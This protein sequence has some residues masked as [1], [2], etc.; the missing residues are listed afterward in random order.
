MEGPRPLSLEGRV[1]IVTGAARGIGLAI[2]RRLDNAGAS[3]AVLDL[4]GDSATQAAAELRSAVASTCDVRD[5]ESVAQAVRYVEE[6]L[7]PTDILVNNAGIWSHTPILDDIEETWD[8]IFA[9]NVKGILICSK[10]VLSGMV[11]RKRGKI[12]NISSMSGFVGH[13]RWA[14]YGASKSA[15]ISLTLTMAAELEPH[16]IQVHAV[17]PSGTE[18]DMAELIQASEPENQLTDLD[19]PDKVADE[20]LSLVTPFDIA[21]TGRVIP[22]APLPTIFGIPLGGRP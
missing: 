14:A 6:S 21:T 4:D 15:A 9:T 11:D 12:V 18:T 22:M 13:A 20:V 10:A 3:V 8:D 7:G 5:A 2:A 16:N 19:S 17:C 1:A